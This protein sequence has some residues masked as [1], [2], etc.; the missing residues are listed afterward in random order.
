VAQAGVGAI[1]AAAVRLFAKQLAMELL[2]IEAEPRLAAAERRA[3]VLRASAKKLDFDKRFQLFVNF[4][5]SLPR[6]NGLPADL[7]RRLTAVFDRAAAD[8]RIL[9]RPPISARIRRE[10]IADCKR[11]CTYCDRS[12]GPKVGPDGLAWH[13]DHIEPF[14][15]GGADE[16]DN[17]TLSCATCNVAK[18]TQSANDFMRSRR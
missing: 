5:K 7:L 13:I 9:K 12:G 6:P 17:F 4:T 11:T 1:P 16:R 3:D 18:G 10:V 2:R 8:L 14:A 15:F